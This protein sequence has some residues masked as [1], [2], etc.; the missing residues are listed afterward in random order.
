MGLYMFVNEDDRIAKRKVSDKDI[1][2]SFQ[3]AL[4]CDSSLMIE[5]HVHVKKGGFLRK[6]KVETTYTLFH[7]TPA[8]DGS[9]YQ[10]RYQFSGSGEKQVVMAYLHGIINGVAHIHKH[11]H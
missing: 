10:A 2:E 8:L 6:D 5:E 9:P 3:E 11:S 1:N 7:E 4:K